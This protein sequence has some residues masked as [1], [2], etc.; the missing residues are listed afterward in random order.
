MLASLPDSRCSTPASQP[1]VPGYPP[2]GSGARRLPPSPVA[3]GKQAPWPPALRRA[4]ASLW[5]KAE[6]QE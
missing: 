6:L 3:R 4:D 1:G 2:L 5:S